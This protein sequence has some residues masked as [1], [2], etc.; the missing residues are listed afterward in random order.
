[1]LPSRDLRESVAF[2]EHLGFRNAGD[3]P[4]VHLYADA[5][6]HARCFVWVD[7]VDALQ[8]ERQVEAPSDTP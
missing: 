4:H 3:A 1:M 7:D 2:Y 5:T 8:R 6:A